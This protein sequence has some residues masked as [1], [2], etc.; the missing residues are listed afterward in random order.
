MVNEKRNTEQKPALLLSG[1]SAA[2]NCADS[3]LHQRIL[4]DAGESRETFLL[5]MTS[6]AIAA[7]GITLYYDCR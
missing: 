4:P 1:A 5:Q 6:T 2:G 3:L 7:M